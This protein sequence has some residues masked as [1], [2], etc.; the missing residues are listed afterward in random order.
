MY[1]KKGKEV[2]FVDGAM[3]KQEQP[4]IL[5]VDDIT[6]NVEILSGL[7]EGDEVFTNYMTQ[8][9]DSYQGY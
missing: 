5:I 9:A 1:R 7:N 4:K 8:Q 6:M 3:K 2:F